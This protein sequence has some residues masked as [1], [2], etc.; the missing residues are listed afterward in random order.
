[1]VVE[2]INEVTGKHSVKAKA[3]NIYELLVQ[4]FFYKLSTDFLFHFFVKS[5]IVIQLVY[6]CNYSFPK[7]RSI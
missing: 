1:M 4:V 3:L 5:C 2:L 6:S 7:K